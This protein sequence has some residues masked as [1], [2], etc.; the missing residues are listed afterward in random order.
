MG[1]DAGTQSTLLQ[2]VFSN[3]G[4]T[5]RHVTNPPHQPEETTHFKVDRVLASA[6]FGQSP[7]HGGSCVLPREYAR[8]GGN[9]RTLGPLATLYLSGASV[10]VEPNMLDFVSHLVI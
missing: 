6:S 9:V 10:R 3:R 7:R 5:S 1:N 2:Q 4:K 8:T